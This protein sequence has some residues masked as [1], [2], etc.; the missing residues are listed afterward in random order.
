MIVTIASL[1]EIILLALVVAVGGY[2]LIRWQ[3]R[4]LWRRL[5][6]RYASSNKR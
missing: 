1:L 6:E 3:I 4:K 2:F 5:S